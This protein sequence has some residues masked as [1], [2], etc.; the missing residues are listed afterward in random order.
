MIYTSYILAQEIALE[1]VPYIP[2][3]QICHTSYILYQ[4]QIQV[5]W[6][7]E[8]VTVKPAPIVAGIT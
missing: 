6:P 2:I 4:L 5:H 3:I 8:P 7:S 1:I